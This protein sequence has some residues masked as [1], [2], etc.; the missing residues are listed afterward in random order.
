M[1]IKVEDGEKMS[2]SQE[3]WCAG[4]TSIQK[5]RALDAKKV[6][7]Y[8]IDHPGSTPAQIKS[9][10]EVQHVSAALEWLRKRN[11][12]KLTVSGPEVIPLGYL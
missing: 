12:V 9:G 3:D 8:L 6:R 1:R 5:Q 11:F 7:R 10:T 2:F 4:R